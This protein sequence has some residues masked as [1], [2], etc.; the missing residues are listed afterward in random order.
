MQ[1]PS[2]AETTLLPQTNFSD[3]DLLFA[4]VHLRS[5]YAVVPEVHPSDKAAASTQTYGLDFQPMSVDTMR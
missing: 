3:A 1:G 5:K 4:T 2:A